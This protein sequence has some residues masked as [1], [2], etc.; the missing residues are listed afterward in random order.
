MKHIFTMLFV[1]AMLTS[2]FAIE[3]H[4]AGDCDGNGTV[5]ISEVQSAINMFLGLKTP[6]LCVDEDSSGSASIAEVQKTINTFLGL[7][8]TNTTPVA[9]AGTAKSVTTGAVVTLDGSASS[10]VNGDTLT[11]SWS[12]TSKPAGSNASLSSATAV[13]PTFTTDVAGAYVLSLVVNDGKVDSTMAN[14]TIT[15]ANPT[16]Q[17]SEKSSSYF[18]PVFTNVSMPY[19]MTSTSQMSATGIPAPTTVTIRTFNLTATGG[20]FTVTNLSAKDSTGRVVP[21]FSNLSNGQTISAGTPLTFSL[22]SPLTKNY[23]VNLTY[24]FTIAETGKSFTYALNLKTN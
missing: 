15:S 23:T 18:D 7:I 6:A 11:Y 1:F 2:V 10:D 3:S 21:Y 20:N 22:I 17:L 24:T 8:P 4:A 19:Y 5:T 14:V 16:L 13:K 9:N 12:F